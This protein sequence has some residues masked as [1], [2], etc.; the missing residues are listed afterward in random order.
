MMPRYKSSGEADPT[1]AAHAHCGCANRGQEA[2]Y[3][4]VGFAHLS[5][6]YPTN[7]AAQETQY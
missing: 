1:R 3:E 7:R 2:S 6:S 5:L 4:G